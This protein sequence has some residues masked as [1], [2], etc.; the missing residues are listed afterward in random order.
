MQTDDEAPVTNQ[1]DIDTSS[2]NVNNKSDTSKKSDAEDPKP[3]IVLTFRSEKSGAKSTN[4]KIVSTEEK[5]EEISPRRSSRTRGIKKESDE[6]MS[7]VSHMESEDD[8][9]DSTQKRS[10]RRISKEYSDVIANAI[11][12]KEK[13]YDILT[14]SQ[15]LSRRIKPTAKILANEE[16][17]MGLES[18]NNARLGKPTDKAEEGIRTRRSAQVRNVEKPAE[19]KA[20][21]RKVQEEAAAD[22]SDRESDSS[23]KK[24]M[25]LC[26]LGLKVKDEESSEAEN[27]K[28]ES[29]T[30]EAAEDEDDEEDDDD[31]DDD[32]DEEDEEI[33]D[34]TEVISKLLEADEASASDDEFCPEV[35]VKKK[36]SK[37]NS[38]LAP[39]RRSS[40]KANS[41]MYYYDEFIDD[42]DDSGDSD[43]APKRNSRSHDDEEAVPPSDGEA[44]TKVATEAASAEE[45][46]EAA[47]PTD[48]ST[49]V[50]TCHC[51]ESTNIYAAP[52]E[53]NAPVFCQAIELVDGVR[54]GCSHAAARDVGGGLQALRRA[55]PRAPFFLACRQ[56]S[57]QL[58]KHMCCP[59]CGLFCTQGI[60]YQCS[61]DHLF[62]L[63][64]GIASG[65]KQK[66]GC[67]HCGV[68]S[69]RWLPVNKEVTRVRVDM[70][71]SNKR[72]FLPD[73]R[74]QCVPAFLGFS[75]L[76]PSK[77][78]QSP[79]IPEDLL[80]S[81]PTDLKSLF[82][83]A[84]DEEM[85]DHSIQVLF[86]AIMAGDP[87][88]QLLPKIV[89]GDHINAP[90]AQLEGGTCVHA[91][92]AR[93]RL[94]ALCLLQYAGANIDAVDN[95]TRTPL[96]RAILSLLDKETPEEI[97]E[98]IDEEA[99]EKKEVKAI[100]EDIE[101]K[102]EEIDPEDIVKKER[103]DIEDEATKEDTNN[104]KEDITETENI[105]VKQECE[106]DIA[107][108]LIKDDKSDLRDE[109]QLDDLSKTSDEDLVKVI[110]Y[111]VA[112]GCDVDKQGPEGMTALH[113]AAHHGSAAVCSLLLQCGGA[114]VDA[115]DQGGWTPLVRAAENKHQEVVKLLL[116]HGADPAASDNEGNMAV[117][118]CALSGDAR[119]LALLLR[120]AP[121]T[122][123]APNAHTDTPLHVAARE[124]H[125][126]CVVI[127]L[128]HG[129]KTDLENSA[130]ELPMEISA[131]QCRDAINLNMQMT[132]AVKHKIPRNRILSSDISN[133]RELY[134]VPCVNEVDDATLPDDFVYVSQHVTHS[135]IPI[136]D[137]IETQQGCACADVECGGAC[138]CCVLGVR[139]WYVRGRLPHDF[140]HHDPPMLFECNQTCGCNLKRCSNRV[141]SGVQA[142]GSL[143]ARVQVYRTARCGWGLRA[144]QR[145]PRGALVALYRGELLAREQADARANDHY[146]FALDLKP[147]LLEECS[148][149]TQLCVDAAGYGSAARFMNHSCRPTVAP[150]RV[151][152]NT[153]DLRLP[154]VALFAL[155]DLP[156]GC[157]LTF[158]Y[159]DKFW[160]V[161]S[162]WIKC[163][164]ESPDCRY[165]TK[166]VE[167][168]E[169]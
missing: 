154:N 15:R 144:G 38:S 76:E 156:A 145:V 98:D 69:Y 11:A 86:D 34:D 8:S 137:S 65:D 72:V 94:S 4:M 109:E 116:D 54:V 122:L 128:A 27:R 17:R 53:L 55:G 107:D 68:Y 67:P 3:R 166:T 33:D 41:G 126:A 88:E 64:C 32:D 63:E 51:E 50:A 37:R 105:V 136:D 165:P 6:D 52:S 7:N 36:R 104:Q 108:D 35:T 80:P 134:P 161:K 89:R 106:T 158:D 49:I 20:S 73:Q 77:L 61:K 141:V 102:T 96:M 167:E 56:H 14:P 71:C 138:A 159:G 120:A 92:A 131:G 48:S 160:S 25:H 93:G 16:L 143:G 157:A 129:A 111:L 85:S 130:G 95:T 2:E 168:M 114:Q 124:G 90:L 113:L 83:G 150:V 70:H 79:S 132:L 84:V 66:V 163:E 153:R 146:M 57:Q 100:E 44:D 119:C 74:E 135:H 115:R 39:L 91:A 169:T 123:N 155:R 99:C 151:F 24:L 103:E 30:Y 148:D 142:G 13:A 117:H 139:R 45:A 59:T 42:R 133:G 26:N 97:P 31:D 110:K 5:H 75:S 29:S 152:T 18:Q 19:K 10:T 1:E 81:L 125:H 40:R 46:S 127:L 62:H 112:V 162:K 121:H 147:D 43:Y 140:P 60:F 101:V 12:R 58:T 118:W 22:S 164:C 149:K 9:R 82:E 87:V 78:D 28:T 47:C 23:N 21:K